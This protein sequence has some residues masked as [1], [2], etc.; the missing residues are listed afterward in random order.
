MTDRDSSPTSVE[1]SRHAAALRLA[2][3]R[4]TRRL[5]QVGGTD[6]G[7]AA[8]SA[9]D[10]IERLSPVTPS[11]LAE[12]ERVTRPTVARILGRLVKERLVIRAPDPSDGRGS[13]I[14]I[15]DEGVRVLSRVRTRK[16]TFLADLIRDLPDEDVA[17]LVRAAD[18]IEQ[19][20][21]G[22]RPSRARIGGASSSVNTAT[23]SERS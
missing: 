5:R 21:N 9:L 6:L 12:A 14:S 4:M 19:M 15:S 10:S 16:S 17:T 18:L 13:L 11:E 3:T 22:N 1:I 2:V 20:L 7:P 23:R 8:L